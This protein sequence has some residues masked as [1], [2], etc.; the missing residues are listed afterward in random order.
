MKKH[1]KKLWKDL[2][3]QSCDTLVSYMDVMVRAGKPSLPGDVTPGESLLLPQSLL[4][5]HPEFVIDVA[6]SSM[7]D[8]DILPGDR[9]RV[10]MNVEVRDGDVVVAELDGDCTL[11][12]YCTDDQGVT[13][14]VPANDEFDAINLSDYTHVRIIGKVV[15][16]LKPTPRCSYKDCMK[17]I[18]RSRS[19]RQDLRY[20]L[21]DLA[22]L[23]T[24][25]SPH[26]RY[27]RQW[28][29]VC[30][31]LM[32]SQAIGPHDYG[33]F[34]SLV[35]STLPDHPCLP[36]TS[37]LKRLAVFSFARSVSQW[38]PSNAPVSGQRFEDYKKI[39]ELTESIL[40]QY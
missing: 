5:N 31:V 23:I 20:S 28:Y 21:S 29:A 40:R 34:V 32:E 35:L 33:G 16:V 22:D 1:C 11:K 15:G 39:A 26:I 3:P 7:K 17:I 24:R 25:I 36:S 9:V 27:A 14:L 18:R 6:G 4:S 12:I 13:W 10:Q 2:H 8:M 37:E 30:R 38:D 19:K